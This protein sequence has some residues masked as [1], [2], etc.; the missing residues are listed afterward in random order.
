MYDM[1]THHIV[2]PY[3]KENIIIS[4]IG[5][6]LVDISFGNVWLYTSFLSSVYVRRILLFTLPPLAGSV[7]N[8]KRYNARGSRTSFSSVVSLRNLYSQLLLER[9]CPVSC[10]CS[11]DYCLRCIGISNNAGFVTFSYPPRR[12]VLFD[13][14]SLCF[15]QT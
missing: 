4:A 1:V 14:A 15:R 3:R 12:Y 13:F 11:F 10:C 5:Y 2:S 8:S 7:N 9:R 6:L